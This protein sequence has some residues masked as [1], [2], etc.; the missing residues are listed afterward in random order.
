M[1]ENGC[2]SKKVAA[3]V[4]GN[5]LSQ[6]AEWLSPQKAEGDDRTRITGA[7]Q[8]PYVIADGTRR[9]STE[10]PIPSAPEHCCSLPGERHDST[11]GALGRAYAHPVLKVLSPYLARGRS[12]PSGYRPG[13]IEVERPP[14]MALARPCSIA[15][16]WRRG[17][18]CGGRRFSAGTW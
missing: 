11:T 5:A 4:I 17:M 16:P 6:T 15:A 3:I 7:D 12:S 14:R 9:R 2:G 10:N 1:N 13:H 8:W 18:A